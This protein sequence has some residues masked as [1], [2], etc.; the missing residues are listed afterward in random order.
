MCKAQS[1]AYV[2]YVFIAFQLS[3]KLALDLDLL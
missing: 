2:V 3:M 1:L